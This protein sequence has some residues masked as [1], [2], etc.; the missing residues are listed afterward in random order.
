MAAVVNRERLARIMERVLDPEQFL[1]PFGVRSLSRYHRDHPYTYVVGDRTYE[2]AYAPAESTDRMFGGNSNWR[3]PV[4][5]PMNVLLVQSINT[6][7]RFLGDTMTVPDPTGSDRATT[8]SDVADDLADRLTRL[9]LRDAEGRRPVIGDNDYMQHDPHW[10]D[11]VPFYEYFDGDT[12][13]GLGAS[14]QT[15][16][17]A[18]VA[19]LLRHRGDLRFLDFAATDGGVGR[20]GSAN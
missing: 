4:W 7:S 12:G 5:F 8:M 15:G 17:T 20:P 19:L 11:L 18:M 13:K 16:W 2:V 10:R 6:Y 1:S 9:F 14:H 3:G